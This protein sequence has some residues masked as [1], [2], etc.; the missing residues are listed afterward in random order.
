[1]L[2]AASPSDYDG[3]WK[4]VNFDATEKVETISHEIAIA[5]AQ[6]AVQDMTFDTQEPDTFDKE[7]TE[8]WLKIEKKKRKTLAKTKHPAKAVA[9]EAEAAKKAK[10]QGGRQA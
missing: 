10:E 8:A 5:Y 6:A 9:D 4:S 7:T 3:I 2:R 1:M